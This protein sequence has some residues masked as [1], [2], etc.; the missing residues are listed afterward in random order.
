MDI[1][2]VTPEAAL[3]RLHEFDTSDLLIFAVE[4]GYS[5]NRL[6]ATQSLSTLYYWLA[7]HRKPRSFTR[8]PLVLPVGSVLNMYYAIK[9]FDSATSDSIMRIATG[10]PLSHVSI[11]T[12]NR[13]KFLPFTPLIKTVAHLEACFPDES[14]EMRHRFSNWTLRSNKLGL[15]SYSVNDQLLMVQIC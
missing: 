3:L 1:N 9:S 8:V 12:K 5:G 2:E 7:A 11:T 10:A 15:F 4:R 14:E 13:G 6:A